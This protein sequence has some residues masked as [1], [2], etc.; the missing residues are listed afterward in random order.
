[1]VAPP[2][3]TKGH[4]QVLGRGLGALIP[5]SHDRRDL[6]FCPIEQI[7]P[8]SDQPRSVINPDNLQELSDSIHESGV[9]QPV[10]IKREGDHYKLI[11]GER[12]WRAA[13]MAGLDKIPALVR[14]VEDDE[15]FALGLIE[16][17]QREDLTP[18]EEAAA[19]QRLIS[20]FGY[21]QKELAQKI[22]KG[23][24]TIANTMRLLDLPPS[25]R[26]HVAAG[27]LSAGHARAV[28]SV[29]KEKQESFAEDL[30]VGKVT[31]RRAEALAQPQKGSRKER[32]PASP[33]RLNE[34]VANLR[35]LERTLRETLQTRVDIV[36]AKGVGRIEVHYDDDDTLQDI[37][38]RLLQSP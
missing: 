38:D 19:F 31:V 6:F 18:I 17:V 4:R 15:S 34:R 27:R 26:H 32:P 29:P 2:G 1:M 33:P 22:G 5:G 25:V 28:L 3:P 35:R 9:L 23:R 8:S 12:R 14:D 21:T 13:Q 20:E 16:N 10:L 24:S 30:V 36:D 11:C 7:V 37:I